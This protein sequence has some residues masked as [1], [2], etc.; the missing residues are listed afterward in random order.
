M[1]Q[2]VSVSDPGLQ[3]ERTVM[4]WGRTLISFLVV[5][6]VFLRWQP[7]YGSGILIMIGIALCTAAGIYL[8]QRRRYARMAHGVKNERIQADV[9][10]VLVMTCAMLALGAGAI[11]LVALGV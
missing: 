4:A 10:A 2:E 7:H 8:S 6:G 9:V 1:K 5:A 3:P 11:V